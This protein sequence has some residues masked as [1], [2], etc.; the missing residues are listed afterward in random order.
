MD[1]QCTRF[2]EI[3]PFARLAGELLESVRPYDQLV[4]L[5]PS[6]KR[7]RVVDLD[8]ARPQLALGEI[9]CSSGAEQK[10]RRL[11]AARP[12][13]P[14]QRSTPE[15]HLH[16]YLI[17]TA[18]QNERRLSPLSHELIFVTDEQ[19]FHGATRT[20]CD[21][22]ALRETKIGCAPVAIE[23]KTRHEKKRLTAQLD[24]A[25]SIIDTHLEQFASVAQ[26]LLRR[27][28]RLIRPCERWLVWPTTL[29]RV[30]PRAS[31][32]RKLRICVKG[33]TRH[34]EGYVFV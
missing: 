8:P 27:E 24:A 26:A 10:L 30:D 4:H 14:P 7:I 3:L 15:K 12:S 11:M 33:Y 18:Y 17:A 9:T 6:A 31:E 19:L 28:V 32:L 13:S 34:D 20:V 2:D 16:S 5:R 25:T 21:L 22:L 1:D 29:H 23:L